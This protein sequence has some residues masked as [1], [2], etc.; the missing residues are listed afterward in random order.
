MVPKTFGTSRHAGVAVVPQRGGLQ[1]TASAADPSSTGVCG[2]AGQGASGVGTLA[3]GPNS[4]LSHAPGWL[5][6]WLAWLAGW[7]S[8]GQDAIGNM[9]CMDG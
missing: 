6:G 1:A 7:W 9:A 2:M 8:A 5:A 4:I 3:V